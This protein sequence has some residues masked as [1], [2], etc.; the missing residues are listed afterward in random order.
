MGVYTFTHNYT[1]DA[2]SQ[3][4]TILLYYPLKA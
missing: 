1:A 3:N 4:T 2:L